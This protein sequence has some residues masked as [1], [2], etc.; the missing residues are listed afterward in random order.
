MK[1]KQLNLFKTPFNLRFVHPVVV[2]VG[3]DWYG[4]QKDSLLKAGCFDVG[5]DKIEVPT[6]FVFT[7]SKF[8][9]SSQKYNVK[10]KLL[11]KHNPQ[12]PSQISYISVVDV[13]GAQY[14][15]V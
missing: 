10:F 13:N 14:V 15:E 7:L 6:D 4:K 3:Y 8:E 9:T 5:D 2:E 1:V 12:L 11:K